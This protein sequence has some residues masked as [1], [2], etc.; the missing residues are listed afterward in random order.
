L[1]L[2]STTGK[3]ILDYNGNPIEGDFEFISGENGRIIC[4]YKFDSEMCFKSKRMIYSKKEDFE[5][6]EV[7]YWVKSFIRGNQQ[8]KVTLRTTK[9]TIKL[10]K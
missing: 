1:S 5:N 8:P 4:P 6:E 7:D 3:V 9:G 2:G 10:L